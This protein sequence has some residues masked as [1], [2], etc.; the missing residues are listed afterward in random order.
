MTDA[1]AITE[2]TLFGA[3]TASKTDDK[4]TQSTAGADE[5]LE[6]EET[7]AF[8]RIVERVRLSGAT[9]GLL[10]KIQFKNLQD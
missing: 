4:P 3:D 2:A 10:K 7:E 6:F 1:S 8:K 5:E 9:E